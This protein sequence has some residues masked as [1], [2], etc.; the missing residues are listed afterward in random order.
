MPL[1][2]DWFF[3]WEKEESRKKKKHQ[4]V[5]L[6]IYAFFAWFLYVSWLEMEPA[7]VT[8]LQP[9]ELTGQGHQCQF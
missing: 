3:F 9:T 7:T 6:H 5:G 8:M 2:I 4:F 1:P